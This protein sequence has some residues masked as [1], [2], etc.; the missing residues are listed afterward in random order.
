MDDGIHRFE[1]LAGARLMPVFHL[2][3][4]NCGHLQT[5]TLGTLATWV[6]ENPANANEKVPDERT[7]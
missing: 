4:A 5:H 7:D 3:C 1:V 2:W 6:K